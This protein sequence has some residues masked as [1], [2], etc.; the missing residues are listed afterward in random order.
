MKSL[1]H[2]IG[3]KKPF[4]LLEEE[5]FLNMIRATSQF[6]APFSELFK[7]HGLSEATYNILRILRGHGGPGRSC[8][9]IGDELITRVPDVTRL[10]DRLEQLGLVTRNRIQEDRRV[11]LIQ[12]TAKGLE[13]LASIDS[14]IVQLQRTQFAHMS[15]TDLKQLN[16]LLSVAR[17]GPSPDQP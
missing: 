1:Q 14:P 11:V 3:K 10:V 15:R 2:E 6:T 17:S 7:T 8:G 13:L 9:Q 4:D 16:H 5:V 12:I